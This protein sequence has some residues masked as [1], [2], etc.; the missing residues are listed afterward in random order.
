MSSNFTF[1]FMQTPPALPSSRVAAFSAAALSLCLFAGCTST[2]Y[3]KSD[4]AATSMQHAASEVQLEGRAM[5][6]TMAILSELITKSTGDLRKPY[7]R[8]SRSLDRLIASAERSDNTAQRMEEK[9][10]AYVAEW[11][12]QLDAIDYGHIHEISEARRIEV[13]NRLDSIQRRYHESQAAVQPLITY[14]LDI[15]R[16]LSTDLTMAGLDSLKTVVQNASNNVVKV[17][18]ALDALT[19]ELTTSSARL[20]SVAYQASP[21]A[22][23]VQ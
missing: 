3:Q 1:R 20:S 17:Q 21:P 23:P 13:T 9:N 4:V 5:D 19:T 22:P 15:R 8:Y 16:A 6:Q 7:K 2:G 18:T 11:N 14:L 10:A 12:R